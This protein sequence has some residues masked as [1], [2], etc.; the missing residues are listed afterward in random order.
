[1]CTRLPG[2]C[3]RTDGR[4]RLPPTFLISACTCCHTDNQPDQP[5]GIPQGQVIYNL[6]RGM[7]MTGPIKPEGI[8]LFLCRWFL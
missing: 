3:H 5:P 7:I 8:R 6:A 1:M 4:P 2:S